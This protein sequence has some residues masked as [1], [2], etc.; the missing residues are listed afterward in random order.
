[1]HLIHERTNDG[2]KPNVAQ[3]SK[4][5]VLILERQPPLPKAALV[6]I[7]GHE[8]DKDQEWALVFVMPYAKEETYSKREE[9]LEWMRNIPMNYQEG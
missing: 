8:D 4:R 1:M 9:E 5:L 6:R 7:V 2:G 3:E